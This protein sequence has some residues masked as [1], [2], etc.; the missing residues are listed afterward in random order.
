[1]Q[2][3][4]LEPVWSF[5]LM[6]ALPCAPLPCAVRLRTVLHCAV[7]KTVNTT[8]CDTLAGW[9]RMAL[10]ILYFVPGNLLNPDASF[11]ALTERLVVSPVLQTLV[12]SKNP[13]GAREWV[14]KVTKG[15]NFKRVIPAHFAAPVA[16]GP[17]DF[18]YWFTA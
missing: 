16:A 6:P 1:M 2:H 3:V 10:Q 9:K 14:E 4:A 11:Q 17:K 7:L 13:A 18:R 5:L 8:R 15:W 12:Y